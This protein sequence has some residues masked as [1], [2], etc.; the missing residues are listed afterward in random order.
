MT[1]IDAH[2]PTISTRERYRDVVSN[3][4]P[5]I[6][7]PQPD[8]LLSS[9]L[10]RLAYANGVAPRAFARVL[11]LGA[12][13][14]SPSLDVRLPSD[15]ASLLRANTGISAEQLSAMTLSHDPP[16]QLRLRLRNSGRRGSSTW[17]QFCSQCLAEDQDPY[18]RRNWRLATRVACQDH[19]SG[20]RDR[21]TSC[22][23]HIAA[24]SQGTLAPQHFCARCGFD[25]RRAS[26]VSMSPA[27]RRLDLRINEMCA[28]RAMMGGPLSTVFVARLLRIPELVGVQAVSSLP[29]LST[30]MRIRCFERLAERVC[31]LLQRDDDCD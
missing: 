2:A 22:R 15:V 12:G 21:C 20:L 16:E 7:A 13:M 30:S 29:C 18:F 10:H 28:H 5:V 9:W 31:N 1:A 6:V 17:L 24:Y 4:W 19:R 11:G 8:E 27:A 26:K 23:S 3:Q 14:W 25:L